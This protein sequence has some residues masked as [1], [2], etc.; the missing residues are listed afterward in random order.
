MAGRLGLAPL[1][2]MLLPR[3]VLCSLLNKEAYRMKL[4]VHPLG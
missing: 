2:H 1:S 3:S 4:F